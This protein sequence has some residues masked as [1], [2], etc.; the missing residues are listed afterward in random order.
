MFCYRMTDD[1]ASI[2]R[3][4][5]LPAEANNGTNRYIRHQRHFRPFE[6]GSGDPVY[7]L[8]GM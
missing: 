4:R 8:K 2:S 1:P 3:A 5:K 7:R 6:V